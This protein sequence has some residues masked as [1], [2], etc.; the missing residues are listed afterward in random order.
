[1]DRRLEGFKKRIEWYKNKRMVLEE[2]LHRKMVNEEEEKISTMIVPFN[3]LKRELEH[4]RSVLLYSYI[5]PL[6][7]EIDGIEDSL[8]LLEFRKEKN[9]ER[10]M[11]KSSPEFSKIF[12]NIR[13][14]FSLSEACV[15]F[16]GRTY[17]TF[18]LPAE[19]EDRPCDGCDRKEIGSRYRWRID[20]GIGK[21]HFNY[22]S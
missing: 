19:S 14:S 4:E 18:L 7:A 15:T 1:M 22:I 2:A 3:R 13:M 21:Q 17:H 5:Y 9:M 12:N 10:T 20:H 11:Y 6:Q 16:Q 8:S